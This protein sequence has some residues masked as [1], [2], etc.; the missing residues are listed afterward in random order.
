VYTS[1]GEHKEAIQ[2]AAEKGIGSMVEKPLSTTYTDALQIQQL[3]REHHVPVLV[4]Y[5]TTWY[6]SNTAAAKMLWDGKIGQ[7]RKLLVRD[8]HEGPLEIGV[9]PEF[10]G[11]LTDPVK[12]GAGA[13]FD[14]G[15]YGVDLSTWLMHGEEPLSVTAVTS[16]WKP[17]KYPKTDDESIIILKYKTADAVIEGS[18][19]WPFGIKNMEVYGAT[20]YVDT[21]A[22][23]GLRI[24]TREDKAERTET[25]PPLAAPNDTPL[26]YLAAVLRGEIKPEGD[27]NSLDT[28][29][30]V[31]KI[32]D[33]A[34]ESART[35]RTIELAGY[36]GHA[37]VPESKP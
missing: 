16:Q 3:S 11:W 7:L 21:D 22:L 24:R 8:G 9:G 30:L 15:C 19:N 17:D 35:G 10:G 18:W 27:L 6:A 26:H 25:A 13:L 37:I 23:T 1:I 2:E 29:V 36:Q 20:G 32:L 12:N 14:F 34:R 4:N 33:A 31:V 28:N 5:E